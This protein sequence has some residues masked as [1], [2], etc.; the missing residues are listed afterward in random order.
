M[1]FKKNEL[2]LLSFF[3]RNARAALTK[4][5]RETGVPVSTVFDK[6]RLYERTVI[7]KHTALLDFSRLGYQ[8]RATILLKTTPD[9]RQSLGIFLKCHPSINTIFRVNN[10]F[11]FF[12]DAIFRT[13]QDLDTFL[14]QLELSRGVVE[15]RIHF[16]IE[17]VVRENF[18]VAPE[19]S[20]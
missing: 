3:R 12:I 4:I 8:A 17:E 9:N 15:K 16:V 14:E 13:V 1:E 20:T 7:T 5:S 10:G 11:D 6:L 2:V 18:L 19:I